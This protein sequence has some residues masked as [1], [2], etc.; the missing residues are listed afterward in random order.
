M[1]LIAVIDDNYGMMFN[2]RRQ[3]K[4]AV[5]I[6]RINELTKEHKLWVSLYT[7]ALFPHSVNIVLSQNF[8]QADKDDYCF[9]E[10]DKISDVKE[11]IDMVYLYRWNREYPSDTTFPEELLDEFV[12]ESSDEFQG[13]SHD[14]ITEEIYKRKK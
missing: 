13:N 6:D 10:D 9:I 14:K 8:A 5:L 3:S 1:K 7:K 11:H 12:L 2:N 4:D